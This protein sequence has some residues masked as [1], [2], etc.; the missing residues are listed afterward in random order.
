MAKIDV[1]LTDWTDEDLEALAQMTPERQ[2]EA[3]AWWRQRAPGRFQ[4]LLDA[5]PASEPAEVAE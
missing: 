2:A 3:M 4:N 1:S 5:Q